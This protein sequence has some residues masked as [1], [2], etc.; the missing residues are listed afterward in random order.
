MTKRDDWIRDLVV[1]L[2][3]KDRGYKSSDEL[4]GWILTDEGAANWGIS[5]PDWWSREDTKV[6]R[7]LVTNKWK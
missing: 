5:W 3:E 4:I 2:T 1:Q 7:Q 6:L